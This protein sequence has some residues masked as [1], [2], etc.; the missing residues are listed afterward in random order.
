MADE[1]AFGCFE[2]Q[3]FETVQDIEED[4]SNTRAV[5]VYSMGSVRHPNDLGLCWARKTSALNRI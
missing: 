5:R 1:H 3:A 4:A 2:A